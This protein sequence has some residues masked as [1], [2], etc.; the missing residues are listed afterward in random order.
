V[1]LETLLPLFGL[2]AVSAMQFPARHAAMFYCAAMLLG[3]GF[4]Y[5]GWNFA[6]ERSRTAARRLLTASIIYLPLLFG[7]IATLCGRSK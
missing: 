7:L 5:F 1:K 2:I 3:A 6:F 4:T